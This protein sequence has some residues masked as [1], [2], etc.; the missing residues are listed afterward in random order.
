[1]SGRLAAEWEVG[2]LC[3][4]LSG[5]S[6]ALG[7]RVAHGELQFATQA[8]QWSWQPS[9]DGCGRTPSQ[10][11]T[12]RAISLL[13]APLPWA[14]ASRTL[15]GAPHLG[16]VSSQT[17]DRDSLP[18]LSPMAQARQEVQQLPH[19][20]CHQGSSGTP[21]DPIPSW[22]VVPLSA[23]VVSIRPFLCCRPS[24]CWTSSGMKPGT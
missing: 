18:H 5:T 6:L 3:P 21:R 7:T 15:L 24:T 9:S 23:P 20:A 12:P 4:H 13:P 11:P 1:M 14:S 22:S 16:H 2:D 17:A 8:C 19:G 10:S